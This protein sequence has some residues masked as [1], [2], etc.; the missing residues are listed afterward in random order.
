MDAATAAVAAGESL[1]LAR[2]GGLTSAGQGH[3][4]SP[5]AGRSWPSVT[6]I[7]GASYR[8]AQIRFARLPTPV[9][10]RPSSA[11]RFTDSGEELVDALEVVTRYGL[12][13]GFVPHAVAS[14][15]LHDDAVWFD[16]RLED[17]DQLHVTGPRLDPGPGA[18]ET[19]DTLAR[20]PRRLQ[21]R[22]ARDRFAHDLGWL[23]D[24]VDDAGRAL[25][26]VFSSTGKLVGWQVPVPG[27]LQV[28]R[29]RPRRTADS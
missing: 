1:P 3:A 28:R 11:L 23:E 5:R 7:S 17:L 27:Q 18:H 6:R 10:V 25:E 9:V 15:L 29:Y 24:V 19:L 8:Q 20:S 21:A 4:A 22:L 13:L 14:R 26:P 2:V 16:G 12:R